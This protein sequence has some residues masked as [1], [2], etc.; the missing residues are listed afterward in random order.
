MAEPSS[1]SFSWFRDF[2]M[3]PWAPKPIQFLGRPQDTSSNSRKTKTVQQ[4]KYFYKS[5]TFGNQFFNTGKDRHR[6]IMKIRLK[7][8]GN[9]GY[10]FNIFQQTWNGS[11]VNV[12]NFETK[13]P[14]N[15]ETKK[16]RNQEP[17]TPPHLSSYRLPPLHPTTLFWDH[18]LGGT[19]GPFLIDN[20]LVE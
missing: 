4:Y 5:E 15:F 1:P 2:R 9:L 13:K 12:W 11:L 6:T 8:I 3:C 14:R 16:L 7:V 10:G 20:S 17:P 19:R 18:P